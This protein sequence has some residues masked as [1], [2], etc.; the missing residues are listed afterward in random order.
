MR[1][2]AVLVCLALMSCPTLPPNKD[3]GQGGGTGSTGGGPAG[4]QGGGTAGG[5]AAGGNAG[6]LPLLV[7]PDVDAGTPPDSGVII[8]PTGPAWDGGYDTF[9]AYYAAAY[10]D[11]QLQCDAL[12]PGTRADCV[13]LY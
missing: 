1:L 9:C 13:T 8:A 7:C 3:G 5:G 10:C 4:G 12:V 2:G 11:Y 6:G